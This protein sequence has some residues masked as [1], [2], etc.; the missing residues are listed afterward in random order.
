MLEKEDIHVLMYM[1]IG[2]RQQ[3]TL[4]Y[5][6]MWFWGNDNNSWRRRSLEGAWQQV[7]KVEVSE[8]IDGK[9]SLDAVHGMGE[10]PSE[11]GRVQYQN[12]EWKITLL[13]CVCKVL[14]TVQ[15][16]EV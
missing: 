1:Y 11:H 4:L 12:V 13:E 6:P 5:L 10:R 2:I 3:R 9:V 16:C 15:W 8:V 14:N 7:G